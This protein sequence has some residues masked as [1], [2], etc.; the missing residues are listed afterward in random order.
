MVAGKSRTRVRHGLADAVDAE[1]DVRDVN[2][3]RRRRE[4]AERHELDADH[5]LRGRQGLRQGMTQGCQRS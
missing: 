4:V 5:G 3:L 2:A 1:V